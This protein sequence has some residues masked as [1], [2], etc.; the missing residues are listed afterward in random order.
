MLFHEVGLSR[1]QIL[2]EIAASLQD[3]QALI[4]V[5]SSLLLHCYEI[6]GG[7]RD[8]LLAALG[9]FKDRLRIPLWAARETWNRSWDP[10]FGRTPL[11]SP[12]AKLKNEIERFVKDARRFVEDGS[13]T[14][15]QPMSK[16]DFQTELETA[17]ADILR[18]AKMGSDHHRDPDVT[19]SLLIPFINERVLRSDL[20]RILSRVQQ[21]AELRYAHKIPPG[22]ADGGTD[23][24]GQPKGKSFNRYGDVIIWFEILEAIANTRLEHLIVLTRDVKEDWV[25]TPKR[26]NNERGQTSSNSARQ[27]QRR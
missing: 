5:D 13:I 7:A 9:A 14:Q 1:D 21:E 6:S 12:A 10:S 23:N 3:N 11:K 26:L 18:L 19:S 15:P 4:F 24:D 16:E 17:Q 20:P 8:E 27:K 2:H 22:Y 25:Y